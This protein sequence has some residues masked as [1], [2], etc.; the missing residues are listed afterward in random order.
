MDNSTRGLDDFMRADATMTETFRAHCDDI[1][2]MFEGD[3]D[4]ME[5][6]VRGRGGLGQSR[7]DLLGGEFGEGDERTA[8]LMGSFYREETR[9][10][11]KIYEDDATK[12]GGFEIY[13]EDKTETKMGRELTGGFDIYDENKT[14]KTVGFEIYEEKEEKTAGFEIYEEKEE[15]TAGFEIYDD[16]KTEKTVGFEI[17]EEKEEKTEGFEIYDDNKTDGFEIYDENKTDKTGGFEIYEDKEEKTGGF[18]V[19]DENKT[20]DDGF[21]VDFDFEKEKS[22]LK[23]E[24]DEDDD[25]LE[26]KGEG[27]AV[28]SEV[29]G[30]TSSL[31]DVTLG[32][33][34]TDLLDFS[35]DLKFDVSSPVSSPVKKT[36]TDTPINFYHP[37]ERAKQESLALAEMVE[38]GVP[39][40]DH[41][42]MD[43]NLKSLRNCGIEPTLSVDF[44]ST[45]TFNLSDLLLLGDSQMYVH[46]KIASG[47]YGEVFK[48]EVVDEEEEEREGE[49]REGGD[50][51]VVTQK[52]QVN[53]DHFRAL[54]WIKSNS[55]WEY[56]IFNKLKKRSVEEGAEKLFQFFVLEMES[57]HLYRSSSFLVMPVVVC[58]TL[59]DVIN[60]YQGD[61]TES[62]RVVPEELAVVYSYYVMKAVAILHG[63][64][65]IH[66][67]VKPDNFLVA[68]GRVEEVKRL[69]AWEGQMEGGWGKFALKLIDFGQTIDTR[70]YT[71]PSSSSS[72]SS[73]SS[74]SLAP[75]FTGNHHR[76]GFR[77]AGVVSGRGWCFDVD[78]YGVAGIIHLLLFAKYMETE[79]GEGGE[80]CTTK[81]ARYQQHWKEVFDRLVGY[82]EKGEGFR[83][84]EMTKAVLDEC[85]DL[86]VKY[87]TSN[88]G[89][90]RSLRL[91]FCRLINKMK[92]NTKL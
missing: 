26:R 51:T 14:E 3:L 71:P 45:S 60:K 19:Y 29:G 87:L 32:G 10:M 43:P 63:C 2:V 73:S 67:D 34:I 15:K 28:E 78:L 6:G 36:N 40:H 39:F 82:E 59:N 30:M 50:Y 80:V 92:V 76:S 64:G 89:K 75:V 58:G 79:K 66:S 46:H 81:F 22:S 47:A 77:S 31:K 18:E 85:C 38:N 8:E 55:V 25:L 23:F 16:N 62:K 7:D 74:P 69:P 86:L 54:K 49:E 21:D 57:F 27:E 20:M 70:T 42:G 88:T 24:L 83:R 35:T 17:Y 12:T 52:L 9:T 4:L 41:R 72:S 91:T 90:Q 65:M 1:N 68:M 13:D 33:G 44:A 53:P 56:S 5:E 11:D 61:V 48:V 37:D 84:G